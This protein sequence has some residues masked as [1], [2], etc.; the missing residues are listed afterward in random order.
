MQIKNLSIKSVARVLPEDNF[1]DPPEPTRDPRSEDDKVRP[2]RGDGFVVFLA[3]VLFA[4]AAHAAD[5]AYLTDAAAKWAIIPV[6]TRNHN[7]YVSTVQAAATNPAAFNAMVRTLAYNPSAMTQLESIRNVDDAFSVATRPLDSRF[8]F[9]NPNTMNCHAPLKYMNIFG[10]AS[11]GSSD[12]TSSENGGFHA[13]NLGLSIGA[14]GALMNRHAEIGLAYNYSSSDLKYGSVNADAVANFVTAF[15]RTE[16]DILFVNAGVTIGRIDW[17]NSKYISEVPDNSNYNTNIFGARVVTGINIPAG[18]WINFAPNIGAQYMTMNTGQFSDTA[19]QTFSAWNRNRLTGMAGLRT[20]GNFSAG[21]FSV[22]PEINVGGGYRLGG[23]GDR[24]IRVD[25]P[26]AAVS[27]RTA[28]FIPVESLDRVS[29]NA[30]A[31]VGISDES[32]H[33]RLEYRI[34]GRKNYLAHSARIGF[35]VWF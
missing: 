3:V 13:S 35:G 23:T 18:Q 11:G 25:L 17:Q 20:T 16:Y 4:G 12:F 29:W 26:S 8:Q 2:V 14:S 6:A 28:F 10:R 30:S 31:G 19:E 15:A 34:D 9:C 24:F 1:T 22:R 21:T 27:P 7:P 33:A 5:P 32:I